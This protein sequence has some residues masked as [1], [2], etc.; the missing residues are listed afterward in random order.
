MSAPDD[1]ESAIQKLYKQ[2]EVEKNIIKG[3]KAAAQ[4]SQ[5]SA[6]K[7]RCQSQL[8]DYQKNVNYLES[9]MKELELRKVDEPEREYQPC[10]F[11]VFCT[12]S[13]TFPTRHAITSTR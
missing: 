11:C 5:D 6:F 13:A 10:G 9:M 1:I 4:A 3:T 7:Q 8:T 12:L 2:I